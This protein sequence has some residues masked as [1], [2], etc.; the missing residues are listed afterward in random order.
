MRLLGATP[1]Y[2]RG[3]FIVETMVYGVISAIISI[4]LGNSLFTLQSQA[5]GASSLGLL[6][7]S[8]ASDYFANNFWKFFGALLVAGVTIGALSAL[9]ATKKYLKMSNPTG[10]DLRIWKKGSF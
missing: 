3:P 8:Y 7:V 10:M 9:I 5:F 6:D 2:I 4:T 1:W